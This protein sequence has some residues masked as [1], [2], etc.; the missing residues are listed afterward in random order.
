MPMRIIGSVL[1]TVG[2]IFEAL[3]SFFDPGPPPT[4]AQI[5]IA[6]EDRDRTAHAAALNRE[7]TQR[8][9]TQVSDYERITDA[10]RAIRQLDEQREKDFK[11]YRGDDRDR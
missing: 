6:I 11:R 10:S 9:E 3:F 5:E 2:K 8:H 4:R 1:N 7:Q